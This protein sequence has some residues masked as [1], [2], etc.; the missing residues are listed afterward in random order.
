MRRVPDHE[1]ALLMVG[2]FERLAKGQAGDEALRG[3]Q[4]EAIV[5]RRV[6]FGAAHPYFWAAYTLTGQAR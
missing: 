5:R 4:L 2:F 6:R 1:S 3:A